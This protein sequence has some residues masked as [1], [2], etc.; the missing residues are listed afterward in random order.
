VRNL[1]VAPTREHSRK[2]DQLH[3]DLEHMFPN[4][5]RCELFARQQRACWDCWGDELT[6]F[7]PI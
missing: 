4:M 7:N 6:K 5:R 3:A 2:P 1:I